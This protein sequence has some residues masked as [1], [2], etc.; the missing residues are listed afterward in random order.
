MTFVAPPMFPVASNVML[1]A[2]GS[3][4]MPGFRPT[5]QPRLCPMESALIQDTTVIASCPASH[6]ELSRLKAPAD[7]VS[8]WNEE[9][10]ESNPCCARSTDEVETVS[11]SKYTVGVAPPTPL[12]CTSQRVML[13]Q[14]GVP[15]TLKLSFVRTTSY[16]V[17]FALVKF[18][19]D[20]S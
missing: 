2:D 13:A 7:V 12:A 1:I 11:S 10:S 6:D 16:Q 19:E 3:V 14:S 4:V 17:L 15:T 8:K 5:I 20:M 18:T 9:P